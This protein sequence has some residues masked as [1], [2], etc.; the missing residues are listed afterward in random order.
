MGSFDTSSRSSG[1]ALFVMLAYARKQKLEHS[2]QTCLPTGR[3]V[4]AEGGSASG[5]KASKSD[6]I[7][8]PT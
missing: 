6:D 7:Y 2:E 1:T 4:S 8:P 3:E 5:G